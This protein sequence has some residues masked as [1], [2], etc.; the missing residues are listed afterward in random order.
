MSPLQ[1]TARA[2]R[3]FLPILSHTFILL[4]LA[5][6]GACARGPEKGETVEP[7]PILWEG[8]PLAPGQRVVFEFNADARWHATPYLAYHGQRLRLR[9]AGRSRAFPPHLIQ[10]RIGRKI[11]V[12]SKMDAFTVT[13]PGAIAF[14]FDPRATAGFQGKVGVE[15]TRLP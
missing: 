1:T 8:E 15:I 3:L 7:D 11:G 2:S 5:L 12:L 4:G 13:H 10:F 6:S 14:R 9:R